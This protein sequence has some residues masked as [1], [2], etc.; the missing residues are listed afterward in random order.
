MKKRKI[1]VILIVILIGICFV[2]CG[3]SIGRISK[4]LDTYTITATYNQKDQIISAAQIVKFTNNTS[5]AL[6][7]IKFHIFASIYKQD[8][9]TSVIMPEDRVKA[10]PQGYSYGDIEIDSASVD[11]SPVAFTVE[12]QI[13]SLPLAT[14]LAPES[15]ISIA[16]IYDISLA[17]IHHRLGYGRNTVNLGN[18]FPILCNF[19]NGWQTT[20]YYAIGD[21]F[22]SQVANYTLTLVAPSNLIIASSGRETNKSIEGETA[23]YT[24]KANCVRDFA[25]VMSS[26]FK[27]LTAQMGETTLNYYYFNDESAQ[28]TMSLACKAFEYYSNTFG[29]YPYPTL[30]IAQTDFCY[31]GMEYPSLIYYNANL[32]GEEKLQAIAH[33]IAH[34]WWYGVV[35]N[36]QISS[37]FMDEGLAELSTAMFF[38]QAD[39]F[40]IT[41]ESILNNMLA[42][43]TTYLDVIG[44]YVTSVDTSM[45][46]LDK[47]TSGQEYAFISYV[48]SCLMFN[49][50]S[51]LMGEKQFVKGLAKYYDHCLMK[52]A[53]PSEM[54]SCF[55]SVYGADLTKWF[56]CFFEGKD[57]LAKPNK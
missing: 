44:T 37:P 7:D 6:E 20:P 2:G 53:T 24:Y 25:L 47:F 51:K 4:G 35:G 38:G 27:V 36:D 23:T 45:R 34:Q 55:S 9:T 42:S 16:L 41:K 8:A 10:Y 57:V 32:L 49:E 30:A 46:S 11:S 3:N 26:K 28:V 12:G 52:I 19:D 54:I 14:P 56:E 29:K 5:Q 33:E 39:E 31:G 1:A 15:S 43:Y 13:L 18:W 48:K 40:K 17:N 50:L 22:V 21:P